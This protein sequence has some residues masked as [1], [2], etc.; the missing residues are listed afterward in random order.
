MKENRKKVWIDRFQT[1]LSWRIA[2]YFTFYQVAVWSAVYLIGTIS[3][4][5][6]DILGPTFADRIVF[7][8]FATVVVIGILFIYDAIAFAH[9]IVG[10]LVRFRKVC[11]AIRDGEPAELVKLR[12]GDF[13]Q[14]LRD[15]FNEM[16]QALEQ[17]GAVTLKTPAN[18]PA[19]T[20]QAEPAAK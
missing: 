3:S 2:F 7:L 19:Q 20:E 15:E 9:R 8:V 10:P 5:V 18:P 11:Q 12:K 6:E 14:E 1:Q 4:T 13:L 17:R 16:L